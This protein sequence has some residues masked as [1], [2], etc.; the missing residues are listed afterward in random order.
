MTMIL[1]ASAAPAPATKLRYLIEQ[2]HSSGGRPGWGWG[3]AA[4]TACAGLPWD[5]NR[6]GGLLSKSG[7]PTLINDH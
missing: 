6:D 5:L 4:N 7:I 1:Q 3:G 2:K